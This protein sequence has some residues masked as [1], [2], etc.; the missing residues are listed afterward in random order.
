MNMIV[1]ATNLITRAYF[2][3]PNEDKTWAI[4]KSVNM[5]LDTIKRTNPATMHFC[6][7]APD[8]NSWR[9]E[10]YPDYKAKRPPKPEFLQYQIDLMRTI[11]VRV[12]LTVYQCPLA[13]ADDVIA[14]LVWKIEGR[15]TLLSSDKDLIQLLDYETD[16]IRYTKRFGNP[17]L[18]TPS[19]ILTEFGFEPCY[20]ADYQALMGDT[21]DN[22]PGARGVGEVAAKKLVAKYR[23]VANMFASEGDDLKKVHQYKERVEIS[24]ELTK[25][26]KIVGLRVKSGDYNL[27]MFH[28][29]AEIAR[30]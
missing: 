26:R 10:I 7:D 17:T 13:E 19:F 18:L 21:G 24:Y 8:G 9:K 27:A 2:T 4:F 3:D 22:I 25:L 11:M 30:G 14:S 23:T 16:Y 29:I 1:D 12:G 20:F 5:L 6:F 15:K 28:R